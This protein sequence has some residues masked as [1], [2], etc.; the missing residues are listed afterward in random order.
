[1]KLKVHNLDWNCKK[2]LDFLSQKRFT[3]NNAGKTAGSTEGANYTKKSH[4]YDKFK[5]EEDGNIAGR[6][7]G[8]K[9]GIDVSLAACSK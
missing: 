3:L 9:E 8:E 7:D 4:G 6:I 2:S 1:M 5:T